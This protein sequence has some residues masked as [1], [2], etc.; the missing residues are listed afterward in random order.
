MIYGWGVVIGVILDLKHLRWRLIVAL[1]LNWVQI[2]DFTS[3]INISF[4]GSSHFHSFSLVFA[5]FERSHWEG[6]QVDIFFSVEY[7]LTF[8]II[9]IWFFLFWVLIFHLFWCLSRPPSYTFP[10]FQHTSCPLL[11]KFVRI[12]PKS[13]PHFHPKKG[14]T[15]LCRKDVY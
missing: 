1:D 6:R 10:S 9:L 2:I 4:P 12:G 8:R 7:L 11:S 5:F 13:V 15:F 14:H 3:K